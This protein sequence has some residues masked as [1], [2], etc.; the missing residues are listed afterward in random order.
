MQILDTDEALDLKNWL[1]E[2]AFAQQFDS[3]P[4][5]LEKISVH[6]PPK[7]YSALKKLSLEA[8][9]ANISFTPN[10][11]ILEGLLK[12]A[13]FLQTKIDKINGFASNIL[14]DI[15]VSSAIEAPRVEAGDKVLFRALLELNQPIGQTCSELEEEAIKL[16]KNKKIP[17]P[18]IKEWAGLMPGLGLE[19]KVNNW[20]YFIAGEV[21]MKHGIN[22][23]S[24]IPPEHFAGYWVIIKKL[25]LSHKQAIQ[26]FLA[27]FKIKQSSLIEKAIQSAYGS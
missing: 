25:T 27:T 21:L 1:A 11:A 8:K 14:E 16:G 17:P 4:E 2:V 3:G 24:I 12:T 22:P 18:L 19:K 15:G 20:C 9:R 6:L 5:E 13:K 10:Q 7:F 23:C 26:D